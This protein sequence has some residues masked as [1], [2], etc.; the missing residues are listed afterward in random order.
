MKSRIGIILALTLLALA[1][2][3]IL[4]ADFG[5]DIAIRLAIVSTFL[6]AASSIATLVQARE[7]VRQR[8][9]SER[10][11]VGVFFQ[12]SNGLMYCVIENFGRL[13]ARDVRVQFAPSPLMHDNR[14]IQELS[15]FSKSVPYLP[16]AE[17]LRRQIGASPLVLKLNPNPFI[18][19]V[20]YKSTQGQAYE[21]SFEFDFSVFAEAN[22]PEPSVAHQ[23]G[24]IF[25]L[26]EK[27]YR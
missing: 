8:E 21:E 23:L 13:P 7:V 3:G 14:P 24:K 22:Y 27:Q 12:P 5:T 18:I 16:P 19:T 25:D 10:P 1:I 17:V 15:M 6:A 2:I 9:N 20:L 4:V 11:E 26:L